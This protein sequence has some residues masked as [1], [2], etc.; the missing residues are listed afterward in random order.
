MKHKR[1]T[2][3]GTFMISSVVVLGVLMYYFNQGKK[4]LK[5]TMLIII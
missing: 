2:L 5:Y 1:I 4:K 3:T